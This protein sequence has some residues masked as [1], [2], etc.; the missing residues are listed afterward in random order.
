MA[1]SEPRSPRVAKRASL[2]KARAGRRVRA[3]AEIDDELVAR[4]IRWC[5]ESG[6]SASPDEVRAAL[7]P[8]SWDELIAARAL[9][10]DPPPRGP[11]G[12][13]ALAALARGTAGADPSA[14]RP[15][16]T[17]GAEP[18]GDDR[19]PP[20][21]A[22]GRRKPPAAQLVIRRARD[23][24][25][26]GSA[27][28]PPALPLVD[29]LHRA[30]GRAVLERL[31]RR[32]GGRRARV[33][34]AV[35]AGWRRA[36]GG[37]PGAAELAALLEAHG[38][39]RAFERRERDEAVH[40]VRAAGGLLGRAA[41]DLGIARDDLPALLERVGATG[42]VAAL[43]A[44]RRDELRRRATLSERARLLCED[45][46]RLR[47]LELL[48]EFEADLRARL[49][50]HLR[51]LRAT[52]RGPLAAALADSLALPRAAVDALVR[53]LGVDVPSAPRPPLPAPAKAP[54]AAA[55]GRRAPPRAPEV[56]RGPASPPSA[57][58]RAAPRG[59]S[60]GRPPPRRDAQRPSR[61]TGAPPGRPPKP[62][63]PRG[64]GARRGKPRGS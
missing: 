18:V 49:P 24:V 59:L 36:D 58:G 47:D 33:A 42:E 17:G 21:R 64:R 16:R 45:G 6:G 52:A 32:H 25:S 48:A 55:P 37:A 11:L 44:R 26:A 5:A 19:P 13:G 29:E 12:P 40:A 43:R 15:G 38:L 2:T 4:A 54:V 7:A 1:P 57:G 14:G 46:D 22:R 23:R 31:I 41:A 62:P 61:A 28:P 35:A 9:L 3:V 50:E 30:E 20:P 39:A 53:R 60:G 51:A 8:L 56:R 10:A 34:E 63:A 27:P